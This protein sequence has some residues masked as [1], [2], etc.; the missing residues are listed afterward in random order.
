MDPTVVVLSGVAV[1]LVVVASI[2]MALTRRPRRLHFGPQSH[3]VAGGRAPYQEVMDRLGAYLGVVK[4]EDFYIGELTDGFLLLYS[5]KGQQLVETLTFEQVAALS[6][7]TRGRASA[8]VQRHL[9]A[10]GRFLDNNA[11]LSAAV[12]PQGKG[13]A[14]EYA[15]FPQGDHV[16]TEI[17]RV[18]RYLDDD[19]LDR[20]SGR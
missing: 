13:Y 1:L 9:G 5:R 10:I 7:I 20:L 3:L 11:G 17:A 2:E 15:I 14:I 4:A 6:K 8:A 18:N 12:Y 16:T 19:A